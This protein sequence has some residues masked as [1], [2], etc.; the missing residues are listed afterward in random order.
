MNK[1]IFLQFVTSWFSGVVIAISKKFNGKTD[2]EPQYLF[3]Q[4]LKKVYT[5]TLE[6]SSLTT[7]GRGVAADVVAM[8]TSIPLKKRGALKKATGE[9]TKLGQKFYLGEREMKNLDILVET[10]NDGNNDALIRQEL[11]RD[12]KNVIQAVYERLEGMFLEALSTG[13]TSVVDENNV[14]TE[15]RLNFQHPDANKYGVQT[16]WTEPDSKAMDDI[17]NVIDAADENGV[18]INYMLMDRATFKSF[19][20]S[21]QV[22]IYFASS[23][24]ISAS[25]DYIPTPNLDQINSFLSDDLGVQIII[26]NKSISYEKNGV[27]TSVKPFAKDTVVFLNSLN[28]GSL[29]WGRLSAMARLEMLRKTSDR[30]VVDDYILVSKYSEDEPL[31]EFTKSEALVVPVLDNVDSIFIL[32][33]KSAEDDGTTG[34]ED[35]QTEGDEVFDYKGKKYTKDSVVAAINLA[36]PGTGAKST[37]KD[38]TLLKR[39]N[40]FNA[41]EIAVFEENIEEYEDEGN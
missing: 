37:W 38:A 6:W 36:K 22:K 35:E 24:G 32:N 2:E 33:T 14:G 18:A 26:I 7:F 9:I 31:R 8:D 27:T 20:N 25:A 34:V 19:R 3:M 30:E 21:P 28:V 40:E 11:F 17:E 41:E 1:S 4:M 13:Y 29:V 15:V 16:A 23:I 12:T 39:I 5:P 10:N